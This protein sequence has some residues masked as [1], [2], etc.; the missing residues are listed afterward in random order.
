MTRINSHK[1][2]DKDFIS[3]ARII[4][5]N[6]YDY[7]N[8]EYINSTTKVVIT[9][10]LHGN[11]LQQ[12][13]KHLRGQGCAGCSGSE[14]GTTLSFI[15]KAKNI[16]KDSYD[17]SKVAYKNNKA[18]VLIT[19][20]IH[21]DFLQRPNDHLSGYGCQKCGNLLKSKN[22]FSSTEEFITKATKIHGNKYDYSKTNY[23]SA[24]TKVTI[25]CS[26][27]GEF[28]QTPSSHL[29]GCGCILCTR[30][31]VFNTKDF[32]IKAATVHKDKYDY[33]NTVYVDSK[34]KVVI[35]CP[36]H[37]KFLQRPN[38]HLNGRGCLECSGLKPLTTELFIKRA[39][40]IHG[41]KYD[42]TNTN[43]INNHT[44]VT[45]ICPEHGCFKQT[46]ANHINNVQECP[47]CLKRFGTHNPN[48]KGGVTKDKLILYETYSPQLK[49]YQSTYKIIKDNLELLG[50]E[51]MYCGRVF[52]PTTNAVIGR[53]SAIQNVNNGECNFYCSE[54]CKK[55][56]PTYGRLQYPKGFKP[57]TSREVQPELRK[58][59]LARD[60]YKCQIC[61]ATLE[62]TEL[63]CH[64]IEA[65]SQNP[66]ESADIDNCVTLCKKHHKQVHTLPDCGYHELKCKNKGEL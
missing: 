16:H 32:I 58:L 23:I 52:V 5:G 61:E 62:E 4:H 57:T 42:Y 31:T 37:G 66:I 47:K 12:P 38:E 51:C 7:L 43:Y 55:A 9:C 17:Y 14:I 1:Y 46:P 15:E 45:I 60:N 28:E 19:C 22:N 30:K 59:V 35:I 63:H 36:K 13:Y 53:I 34:T 29:Q 3:K 27:H 48:Y 33:S 40:E 64:H 25:I 50:V 54:N 18:K 21:G 10:P 8:V 20:H 11:F 2:T 6:R 39:Q 56:C 26:E 41:N 49:L 24:K 65:V 44:K